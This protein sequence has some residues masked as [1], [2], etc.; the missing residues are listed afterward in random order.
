MKKTSLDQVY[1]FRVTLQDV[2]PP[3]WRLI[4]VPEDYTLWDLHVAIQDAMGWNDSHLHAFKITD[5]RTGDCEEYGIPEGADPWGEPCT[6]DWKVTT[7]KVFK[8]AGAAADYEY[9]FGDSWEHTVVLERIL[10]REARVKYPRCVDGKNACPPDDCGGSPGYERL[11]EILANPKHEE[12]EEM[13]EW[14]GHPF[15]PRRFDPRKVRFDDPR[16]RLR[17]AFR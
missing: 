9:D 7:K 1:E 2:T 13:Q 11:R 14:I 17:H 6:A 3:V 10:P 5:P 15:D 12:F 4:Q 16:K 8:R